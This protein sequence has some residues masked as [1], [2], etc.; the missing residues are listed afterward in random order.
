MTTL[1]SD[2]PPLPGTGSSATRSL[3]NSAVATPLSSSTTVG[4]TTSELPRDFLPTST[5]FRLTA[6]SDWP[7]WSATVRN[8]LFGRGLLSYLT[9]GPPVD[10]S[11]DVLA[12]W[13]LRTNRVSSYLI[14]SL[15]P[16][17]RPD[18]VTQSAHVVW[19]SL[20]ARFV[21]RSGARQY[22]L[23]TQAAA[24]RQDDRSIQQFYQHMH[25]FW[26]ELEAFLPAGSHIA[27]HVAFWDMRHMY[28]FLMA[29]RPEFGSL[30]GQ[31]IH[32][33]PSPSLETAVAELV[34]EETRLRL[35]GGVRPPPAP[36]S[37][38]GVLAA[39]PSGI[40]TAPSPSSGRPTCTNCLRPGHTLDDCWKLHPERRV[41]PRGR[42]RR[43]STPIAAV[44]TPA[45]PSPASA[46]SPIDI[47]Q[48]QQF[49]QFQQYQQRLEQMTASTSTGSTPASST[50]SATGMSSTWIFDSGASH[51]MTSDAS[52]LTDCSPAPP[53]PSIYTADVG[54]I[55]DFGYDVLFT[56]SSCRVQDPSTS[57]MIGSG[58]RVGGLYHLQSLHLPSSHPSFCGLAS[59]TPDIWHR[60]LG[61]ISESRLK[62]LSLSGA[63]GRSSFSALSPSSL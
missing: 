57:R 26:R 24:A 25:G 10:C 23:L 50:F 14:E 39:A 45:L 60:R 2:F 61:H 13:S 22:S 12:A 46:M 4:L 16:A 11:D 48:F 17:L 5:D 36:S 19:K 47:Q 40:S 8:A 18:L 28:E 9:D 54:G 1:G 62:S 21:E 27:T 29:L 55:C 51:H 20:T 32:R 7:T 37:F 52:L 33:D 15:N 38:S 35:L 41:G 6:A 42:G 49:Q 44:V 43:A 58:R 59:P 34:T 31:L 56:P 3:S 63:L 30:V 53:I